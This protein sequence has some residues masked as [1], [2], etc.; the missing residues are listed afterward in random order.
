MSVPTFIVG[1]ARCGSTMMS[2]MLR[3]HPR[4][5]SLSEFFS[6]VSDFDRARL[7]QILSP[8]PIAGQGF[9]EF[10]A[11]I[12]PLLSLALRHRVE[13]AESIYPCGSPAARFSRRTGVP[14]ILHVTLPHLTDDPD[15][16]FDLLRDEVCAWPPATMG[17]HYQHL[18][19]W[20]AAHF[21]KGLWV[22]RSGGWLFVVDSFRSMFPQSRFIHIVR[23]GRDAALSM[24]E[25]LGFRLTYAMMSLEDLL[26]VNPLQSA[27]RSHI[28]RVPTE[29]RPFLPE[30]FNAEA[31]RAFR[32]PLAFFG[33]L[34]SQW[35]ADGLNG[36][37]ELPADRLLTLRY[38]DFFGDP[39][40][41]LDM[42]AAFLGEDFV[43]ADWSSRCAATVRKPRSTWRDLGEE[44]ARLLTAACQPGFAHLEAVGVRYA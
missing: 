35:I 16:L 44:D 22:E 36:L 34:W 40:R 15:R 18:F 5:L 2:T 10:I 4:V 43:D 21:H 12:T 24:Q 29:L 13:A 38:E 37:R 1:T 3:E 28:A 14:G 8:A 17:G 23:D 27:D 11:E 32:L 19:D 26:G 31:F 39:K 42:L 6:F 33:E 25:H 20:L 30:A 7:A 9:W 41:Q